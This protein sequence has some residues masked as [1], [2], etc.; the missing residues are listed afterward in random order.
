M[1]TSFRIAVSLLEF[2]W[3]I[4]LTYYAPWADAGRVG[5]LGDV[6]VKNHSLC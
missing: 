2:S 5:K 3:I 4:T 1:V 6:K